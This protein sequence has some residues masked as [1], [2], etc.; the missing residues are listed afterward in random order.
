MAFKRILL[1]KPPGRKG[2]S[3]SFDMI[4]TGLE[5]IA[6][7]LK[8][9][10]DQ[11]HIVDMELD[12][13]KFQD[14]INFYKPDLIGITL[15]ATDH[16][17]GLHLAKIAK[18]NNIHTVVGG[19]HPTSV[20]DIMLSHPQIDMVIRGE[21]EVTM[22]ELVETGTFENVPGIS[23]KNNGKI[24]HNAQR[25]QI[26]NLDTLPFPARYLRQYPYKSQDRVTDC[27][28]IVMSRGCN[29]LCS[30]CCEPSMSQGCLRNRSPENVLKEILEMSEHHK[31][32]PVN[33]M[34]ADP[35]FMGNPKQVDRL[36]DLLM[37]HDLN[38]EFCALVRADAMATR[39]QLV[40]K[41]CQVGI[42]RFEMGIESPNIKDLKSTKKGVTNRVHGEAARNI[43]ENGGRAGGTF[44][45]GLPDQTEEEIKTFPTY[46]KEIGLTGAAFGIA[47]PFPGT[48]FYKEIDDQSLIFETNWDNF[49]EMHSVYTTKYLTKEKIEEMATYCMA[50]FWNMDTFID[51]E[52]ISQTRT[53]Q[54]KPIVDFVNERITNLGFM[55]NNGTE[56]QKDNFEKHIKIFL[57]AYID[58][59]V[60]AYTR[61][62]GV[63]EVL[64]MTQF[65]KILGPQKIQCTL[66]LDD[67]H[68]SFIFKTT[69]TTVEYIR[70]IRGRQTDATITLHVDLKWLSEPNNSRII[71]RVALVFSRNL[72]IKKLWNTFRLFAAVGT[73]ALAWNLQK[74]KSRKS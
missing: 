4:P 29:G 70:I 59:R 44:V 10:V 21:G 7:Y 74:L 9:A 17:Q 28:V 11:V 8:D 43:R 55:T 49:D 58:T 16:N 37:E 32:K 56:L 18:Q 19:Y 34:F 62:V 20:P 5:Y 48:E 69:K 65:L 41:M 35:N 73:S 25:P 47:T 30:F 24:I 1:V 36:C 6:A 38:M 14:I 53:K 52:K 15:S 64:E 72:T 68:A 57:E 33:V 3:F 63:H 71:E 39:P 45:I 66:S 2:L 51:H 50:K 31:R 13:R 23:Y 27:D 40:K 26:E 46:A 22:K 61:K 54:K 42:R 67:T 12:K 60:E